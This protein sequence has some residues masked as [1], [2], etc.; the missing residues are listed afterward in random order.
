MIIWENMFVYIYISMLFSPIGL[1]PRLAYSV[2]T[3]RIG[4]NVGVSPTNRASLQLVQL[5]SPG[6]NLLEELD[7]AV[8]VRQVS[9]FVCE[10]AINLTLTRY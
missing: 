4:Y 1:T 3:D 7:K 9:E 8:I 5:L 6:Q 10:I 2:R